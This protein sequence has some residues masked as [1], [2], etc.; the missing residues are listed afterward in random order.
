MCHWKNHT[1]NESFVVF[2]GRRT[3]RRTDRC[4]GRIIRPCTS[5]ALDGPSLTGKPGVSTVSNHECLNVYLFPF[6]L[7]FFVNWKDIEHTD[8]GRRKMVFP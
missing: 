2:A 8:L 1:K 5:A 3:T 7:V 6:V 4:T